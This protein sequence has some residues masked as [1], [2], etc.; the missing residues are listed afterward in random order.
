MSTLQ[1]RSIFPWRKGRLS[2][3]KKQKEFGRG[4]S[5]E[6]KQRRIVKSPRI[7]NHR[8]KEKAER[9][10]GQSSRRFLDWARP[11]LGLGFWRIS[12][13]YTFQASARARNTPIVMDNSGHN[14]RSGRQTNT[15]NFSIYQFRKHFKI[16]PSKQC[17]FCIYLD[18]L[19]DQS[20]LGK[21]STEKKRFLSGIARI[22]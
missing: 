16:R 22:T 9:K 7:K 12:I 6:Q 2:H 10:S 4:K 11:K 19:F 3:F 20:G 5:Q 1:K 18:K 15:G 17:E 13:L 14:G 8:V 21:T